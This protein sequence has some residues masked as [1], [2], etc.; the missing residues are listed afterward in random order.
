MTMNSA[1][2][3]TAMRTVMFIMPLR[4]S[5]G[6]IVTPRPTDTSNA[7]AGL[8]PTATAPFQEA[9]PTHDR[10]DADHQPDAQAEQDPQNSPHRA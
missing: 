6:V 1:G 3:E 7:A 8:G 10:D 9:A 5:S 4:M 2:R